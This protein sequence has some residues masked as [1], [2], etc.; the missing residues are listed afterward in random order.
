MNKIYRVTGYDDNG[1]EDYQIL[2]AA[3]TLT[4]AAKLTE[5]QFGESTMVQFEVLG[6]YF[7]ADEGDSDEG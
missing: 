3:K 2:V 6:E 1:D 7:Y 5:M 4:A